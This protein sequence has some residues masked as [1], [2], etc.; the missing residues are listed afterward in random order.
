MRIFHF[1][2]NTQFLFLFFINK[3][4]TQFIPSSLN[5]GLE[6]LRLLPELNIYIGLE[7]LALKLN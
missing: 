5:S 7:C 6:S 3:T 1:K 2:T 4:N